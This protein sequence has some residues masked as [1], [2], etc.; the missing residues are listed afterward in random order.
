MYFAFIPLVFYWVLL[1]Y[2]ILFLQTVP[3]FSIEH[4]HHFIMLGPVCCWLWVKRKPTHS[5]YTTSTY[6]YKLSYLTLQPTLTNDRV[7]RLRVQDFRYHTG[8]TLTLNDITNTWRPASMKDILA[9]FLYSGRRV[10]RI[11]FFLQSSGKNQQIIIKCNHELI[12]MH[13]CFLSKK[14]I[15]MLTL[16]NVSQNL[17]CLQKM[18]KALFFFTIP[19]YFCHILQIDPLKS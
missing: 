16:P 14:V 12:E 1:F 8:Q 5:L 17:Q 9:S 4:C 3:L 19:F 7:W 6:G 10:G 2:L 18:Q 13:Q 11:N 15:L